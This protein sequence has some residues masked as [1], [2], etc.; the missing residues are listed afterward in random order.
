MNHVTRKRAG[1]LGLLLAFWSAPASAEL[2]EFCAS[3]PGLGTPP[4]T[5]DTGHVMIEVGAFDWTLEKNASARTDSFV[6]GDIAM[7]VGLDDRTE[8][9]I[10]W[11]PFGRERTRDLASG[12]LTRSQST[13]D[14]TLGIRRSLSGPDG[15]VAIQPFV[16]LPTGGVTIGAGDWGVGVVVPVA[17]DLGNGIELALSPQ[18]EAA[19]DEDRSG[20][21]LAYGSVIGLSAPIT[22]KLTGAVEFQATRDDDPNG[23]TNTLLASLSFAWLTGDNTQ[24]DA[25][26]VGGLNDES[27]DVEVYFGISRRF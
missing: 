24:L 22:T 7:R 13:G 25:G 16:T 15:P 27:S 1:L 10:S 19:V 26:L 18:I 9:Q 17:F 5:M 11:S 21:H 2:R 23:S 12:A 3:R 20:R 6:F 4:C 8:V 14:T